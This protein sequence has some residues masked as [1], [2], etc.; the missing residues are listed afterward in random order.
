M[1]VLKPEIWKQKFEAYDS[2]SFLQS[3]VSDTTST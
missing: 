1:E 3:Q 2:T